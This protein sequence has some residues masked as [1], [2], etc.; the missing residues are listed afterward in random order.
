M[1]TPPTENAQSLTRAMENRDVCNRLEQE[2]EDALRHLDA[3]LT[4]EYQ[5]ATEVIPAIV[6]NE[7]RIADFLRAEKNDPRKAASRLA[8]YWKLRKLLFKKRWLLPMTMTGTGALTPAQAEIVRSGFAK[9]VHSPLNGTVLLTDYT[10]LP[11]GAAHA[12][13]EILFYLL[14]I[15]PVEMK[16][17][18]VVR[19]GERPPWTFT[20][21]VRR[22]LDSVAAIVT[23]QFVAQAYEGGGKKH[24]LDFLGYQQRRVSETNMRVAITHIAGNSVASTLQQ[25]EEHG[26]DCDCLPRVLGGNVDQS[27]FDDFIRTR[28]SVEDI[29]SAAPPVANSR[30]V[31]GSA[32]TTL[33]LTSTAFSALNGTLA[34]V[35]SKPRKQRGKESLSLVQLPNESEAQFVKRKNAVYV[36]RNYHRQKLELM[37]AQEE[38]TKCQEQNKLFKAENQR[39]ENLFAQAKWW[40]FNVQVATPLWLPSVHP[41]QQPQQQQ[42]P[43]QPMATFPLFA[44]QRQQLPQQHQKLLPQQQQR[45]TFLY[46]PMQFH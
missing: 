1:G 36:R 13:V 23:Q 32:T 17:L 16:G 37:T 5:R 44:Q 7:T 34:P 29:M 33:S 25:L 24:L 28:M 20:D 15:Y 11:K 38:L 31:V 43:Q 6:R 3:T 40:L 9:I 4:K 21:L 45:S 39:L 10:L 12:Q 30:R 46:Q 14:T 41:F 18:F 19:T 35:S 22:I 27:L 26:F 8:S 42:L 2:V